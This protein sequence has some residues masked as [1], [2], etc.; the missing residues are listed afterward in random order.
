MAAEQEAF[1]EGIEP[2]RQA[3]E[4]DRQQAQPSRTRPLIEALLEVFEHPAIIVSRHGR[5]EYGNQSGQDWVAADPPRRVPALRIA[6]GGGAEHPT[7]LARPLTLD[8]WQLLRVLEPDQERARLLRKA[9]SRWPLQERDLL[10]L[11]HVLQ[12]ASNKE[13]AAAVRCSEVTVERRLTSMFKLAGVGSRAQL[14]ATLHA[15]R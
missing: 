6:A 4:Q 13:I 15:L 8:G 7:L 12:G 11:E 14:I 1:R 5:I 10:V 3:L 2:L 9:S